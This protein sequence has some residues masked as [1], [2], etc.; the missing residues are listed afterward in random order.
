MQDTTEGKTKDRGRR[1]EMAKPT[2]GGGR[3]G[4]WKR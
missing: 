2:T 1:N 3:D 4:I